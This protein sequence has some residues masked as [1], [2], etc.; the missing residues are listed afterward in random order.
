MKAIIAFLKKWVFY[1]IG[2]IF[3]LSLVYISGCNRGKRVKVCPTI[4]TGITELPD[5]VTHHIYHIWPWYIDGKDS[6]VYIDVP[7][8]VDT[9][10]ILAD[11]YAKHYSTKIWQ[12]SIID[13]NLDMMITENKFYPQKFDYHI[14]R[15]QTIITNTIDNSVNYARYVYLGASLPIYPSKVNNVSN[16][17]LISLNG[18]YAFPKGYAE[19]NY[20]PYTKIFTLG[21]G[22]KIFKFK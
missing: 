11:Y 16:I 21:T 2:F 5:T 14:K 3:V 8:V 12:D 7:A 17:N 6:I 20:Q 15:P 1:A 19:L 4:I 18:I 13:V 22:I 10:K 9:M